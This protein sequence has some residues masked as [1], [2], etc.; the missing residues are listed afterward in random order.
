[1]RGLGCT[2]DSRASDGRAEGD[3]LVVI[4]ALL[5]KCDAP[6]ALIF[7]PPRRCPV[8]G[9]QALSLCWSTAALPLDDE[10]RFFLFS[11]HGFVSAARMIFGSV[12]VDLPYL[13]WRGGKPSF[14]VY[15][16]SFILYSGGLV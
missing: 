13:S 7:V 12:T 6:F 10:T 3:C 15:F 14:F 5:M 2:I 8:S 1:M 4:A 16:S 11:L 9:T